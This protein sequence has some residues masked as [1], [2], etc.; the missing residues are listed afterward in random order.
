MEPGATSDE[1][2]E[3]IFDSFTSKIEESD[4]DEGTADTI[5][6]QILADNPPHEFS[7]ELITAV[8]EDNEA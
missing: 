4:I 5:L 3:E 1:I 6:T 2:R 8:G 7:D